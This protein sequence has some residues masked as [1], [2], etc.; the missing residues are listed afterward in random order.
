MPLAAESPTSS[1]PTR[2]GRTATATASSEALEILARERA[3][4]IT[5]MI[6]STCARDATSGTTPRQRACKSSW[7]ATTLD[8]TSRARVTTAAAVSSQ[9]VSIASSG[10]VRL[11]ATNRQNPQRSIVVPHTHAAPILITEGKLIL[12]V[13]SIEILKTD[14]VELFAASAPPGPARL[15]ADVAAPV[16]FLP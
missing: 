6:R 9:V 5:G 7:L 11:Q 12:R 14:A 3:S 4:S 15:Y 13:R 1:E 16:E 2:P 10:T 8:S